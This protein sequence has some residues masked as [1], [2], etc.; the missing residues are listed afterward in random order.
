V[1]RELKAE[2]RL[3]RA[4][5]AELN[6][7]E[8]RLY[9]NMFARLKKMEEKETQA[10]QTAPSS[11]ETELTPATNGDMETGAGTHADK[12]HMRLGAVEAGE[13]PS[14]PLQRRSRGA[15]GCLE[16]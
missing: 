2:L 5:V 1:R 15:D 12:K 10:H 7:K 11:M 8:Q 14:F 9:G 16:F 4:K 3:V 13:E 6:K